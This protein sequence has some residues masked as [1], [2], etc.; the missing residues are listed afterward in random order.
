MGDDPTGGR[1]DAI[2]PVIVPSAIVRARPGRAAPRSAPRHGR[3]ESC[4]H[5]YLFH[6]PHRDVR[7][8]VNCGLEITPS[9][10]EVS[11]VHM[12]G[13]PGALLRRTDT[14]TEFGPRA[15]DGVGVDAGTVT[16]ANTVMD[17]VFD[18]D[19]TLIFACPWELPESKCESGSPLL[20]G[21]G[22]GGGGGGTGASLSADSAPVAH[23][24]FKV[25]VT[26]GCVLRIIVR[27]GATHLISNAG[28]THGMR[29][30]V[31]TLGTT[32]YAQ[33]VVKGLV[34]LCPL[35]DPG[36]TGLGP[37]AGHIMA[38]EDSH[39]SAAVVVARMGGQRCTTTKTVRVL[40]MS[41][42]RVFVLDDTVENWVEGADDDEGLDTGFGVSKAVVAPVFRVPKFRGEPETGP[43]SPLGLFTKVLA[44]MA[45][46]MRDGNTAAIAAQ[47]AAR[48]VDMHP[49]ELFL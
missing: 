14:S 18:L 27:P 35:L 1:T 21:F 4:R 15:R 28:K 13:V 12:P 9:M 2:Q 40:G 34:A 10:S 47:F 29:L 11:Q 19:E 8:C 20:S 17:V 43:V 16:A 5:E 3:G 23:C 41:R 42:D 32:A 44:V 26:P 46:S 37:F 48:R 31:S 25:V 7:M 36:R 49:L 6:D 33:A 22:V 30:W 38:R 39:G 45:A 24:S